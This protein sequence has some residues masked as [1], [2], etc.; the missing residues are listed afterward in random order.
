MRAC[1]CLREQ[2][3]VFFI[4]LQWAFCFSGLVVCVNK[5]SLIQSVQVT[6][7]EEKNERNISM[8]VP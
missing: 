8:M 7:L 3:I 1:V 6:H 2:L 4:R 5:K